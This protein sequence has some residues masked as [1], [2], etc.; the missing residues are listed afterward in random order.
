VCAE[1]LDDRTR[2]RIYI[3]E[4]RLGIMSGGVLTCWLE[5]KFV[6]T[7]LDQYKLC[8]VDPIQVCYHP[9]EPLQMWLFRPNTNLLSPF[10]VNTNFV[11]STQYKFVI[12]L[13]V[14]TNFV[15]STQYK[16]VNSN[17][18]KQNHSTQD[19]RVVPHRGTNWAA[20]RLT[21]QIGR[22]AVL[23]KSYGRGWKLCLWD[24]YMWK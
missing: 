21:A 11:I 3:P 5:Y 15:I 24:G 4:M 17:I 8:Y 2:T 12:S 6:I 13:G 9:F 10:E 1:R 14:N 20:L 18:T 23:S 19:S 16:C 7:S 22:D